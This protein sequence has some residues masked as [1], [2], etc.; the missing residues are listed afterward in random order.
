LQYFIAKYFVSEINIVE[1]L[2]RFVT[3]PTRYNIPPPPN[4][5]KDYT[6]D[7]V[8]HIA[9]HQIGF[10]YLRCYIVGDVKFTLRVVVIGDELV[11]AAVGCQDG[12][13]G[14]INE[15]E[16]FFYRKNV[17]FQETPLVYITKV[18]STDTIS[19]SFKDAINKLLVSADDYIETRERQAYA[20]YRDLKNYLR[21]EQSTSAKYVKI[22]D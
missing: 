11:F 3:K 22:P 13:L 5:E 16:Y 17:G 15:P 4:G 8:S 7:A 18:V 6:D 14:G 12:M 1:L 9:G 20:T 2:K 19:A 10:R 21:K